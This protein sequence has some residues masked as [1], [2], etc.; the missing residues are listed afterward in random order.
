MV[1]LMPPGG[2]T[3]PYLKATFASAKG[4]IRPP[5]KDL[6]FPPSDQE[7]LQSVTNF[8]AYIKSLNGDVH[9]FA[10]DVEDDDPQLFVIIDN[11]VIMELSSYLEG[12][13]A[14]FGVHYAF[15]LEYPKKLRNIYQ[16]LEEYVFGI[17]QKKRTLHYR[18]GVSKLLVSAMINQ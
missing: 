9:L 8:E 2:N 17:P 18:K 5:Q 12:L 14:V 7:Q 1:V 4:Y 11:N 6:V 16:F 15:N 3:V 10:P 13:I